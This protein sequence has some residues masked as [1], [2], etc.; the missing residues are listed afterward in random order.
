M[1]REV[2]ELIAY[3]LTAEEG[4]RICK[5][6]KVCREEEFWRLMVYRR[7][8]RLGI[9]VK[10]KGARNWKENF[11]YLVSFTHSRIFFSLEGNI[12][13]YYSI[14]AHNS[15]I[16]KD[17]NFFF[18][19]PLHPL[20]KEGKLIFPLGYYT[21]SFTPADLQDFYNSWKK[22]RENTFSTRTPEER[23]SLSLFYGENPELEVIPQ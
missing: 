23:I 18:F 16:I 2:I 9:P 1:D 8:P 4:L 13:N 12:N 5:E 17:K 21:D 20:K 15:R 11:F 14:I 3:G 10:G 7:F 22:A 6:R 19:I